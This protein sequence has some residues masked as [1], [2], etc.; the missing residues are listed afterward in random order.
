MGGGLL[1]FLKDFFEL[2]YQG[3]YSWI[4]ARFTI[5]FGYA[6]DL[7]LMVVQLD[8]LGLKIIHIIFNHAHKDGIF[9]N[10]FHQFRVFEQS[11][12]CL[13]IIIT[14]CLN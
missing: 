4:V 5:P 7:N 10:F 2:L 6:N 13:G 11:T 1:L 14:R 8:N 9:H 12:P 3:Q